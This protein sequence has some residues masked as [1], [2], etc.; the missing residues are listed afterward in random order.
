MV[1]ASNGLN[2]IETLLS[3]ALSDFDKVK[4]E[5]MK[6]NVKNIKLM[7]ETEA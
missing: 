6:E 2:M 5:G 1:L 7:Q 4:Y 3:S